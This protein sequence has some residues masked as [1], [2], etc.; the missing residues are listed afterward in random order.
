M[1][2]QSHPPAF[3]ESETGFRA[4]LFGVSREVAAKYEA[5][6]AHTVKFVLTSEGLFVLSMVWLIKQEQYNLRR[7]DFSKKYPSPAGVGYG[8]EQ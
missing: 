7:K 6:P 3:R 8:L 1:E 2:K 4:L 5:V